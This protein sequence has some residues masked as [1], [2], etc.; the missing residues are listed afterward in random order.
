MCIY[1]QLF[2][3]NPKIFRYGPI[4]TKNCESE[5]VGPHFKARTVKF[6][7]SV[8]TIRDSLP[9][10]ILFKKS[11]TGVYLFLA[12]LY[13]KLSISEIFAAI[14]PHFKSDIVK[15]GTRVRAWEYFSHAKFCKIRLRGYTPLWQIYTKN[16]QFWRFSRISSHF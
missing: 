15:F 10:Q 8:R 1:I 9:S 13:Q 7:I 14:S 5:S 2:V 12:N 6:G 4:Y 16:Y 11:L 3:W